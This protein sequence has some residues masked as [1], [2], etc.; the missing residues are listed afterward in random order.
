MGCPYSRSGLN[1]FSI[2]C[3]DI[4][5]KIPRFSENCEAMKTYHSGKSN[6]CYQTIR[7]FEK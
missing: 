2:C 1:W 3:Y 5:A 6:S 7:N 4:S